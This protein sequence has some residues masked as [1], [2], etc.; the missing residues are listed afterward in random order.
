VGN[1]G[2]AGQ[3]GSA[4]SRRGSSA[5]EPSDGVVRAGSAGRR[6]PGSGLGASSRGGGG[7]ADDPRPFTDPIPDGGPDPAGADLTGTDLIMR[8]LGGRMIEE[9]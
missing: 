3:K 7:Q 4:A 2:A 5:A 6:T 1:E 9:S 8:E